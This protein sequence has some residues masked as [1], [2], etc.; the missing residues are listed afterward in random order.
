MIRIEPASNNHIPLLAD[1]L[2]ELPRMKNLMP[3][4]NP[5]AVMAANIRISDEAWTAFVD[6]RAACMY[7]IYR[8]LLITADAV[9]WL[10]ATDI[11]A[12]LP[13]TFLRNSRRFVEAASRRYSN[14]YGWVDANF[15]PSVNWLEWLGFEMGD[16]RNNTLPFEMRGTRWIPSAQ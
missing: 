16:R 2:I 12:H 10:M 1:R 11:V 14:L 6:D 8:P 4:W 3:L 5:Q 9:P 13:I 15:K 7:G